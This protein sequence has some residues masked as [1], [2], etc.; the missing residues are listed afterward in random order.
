MARRH[1]LFKSDPDTFA[2]SHLKKS[3]NRTT[4]WDG[5]RLGDRVLFYHSRTSPPEV[6][7]LAKVT[8]VGYPD[9]TRF[10]PKSGYFDPKSTR[11]EPRWY[12]VDI[13]LERELK[14]PVSLTE[15][16]ETQGLQEMVLLRRS[17]LSVQP[18]TAEE[19]KI[20]TGLGR[21]RSRIRLTGAS[22]TRK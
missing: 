5:V 16:R 7:A 1:W 3:K 17:R 18:V 13:Q 12:A 15:L 11:D 9:P 6:V 14:R 8:R 22:Q 10:Q 4:C 21:G 19:W 20:I 2:L